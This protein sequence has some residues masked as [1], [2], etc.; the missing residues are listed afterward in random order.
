MKKP[1]IIL[2]NANI[3]GFDASDGLMLYGMLKAPAKKTKRAILHVHGL[4]GSFYGSNSVPEI[5]KAAN[6]KGIAFMSI[7]TRGSYV[8]E[9]FSYRNGDSLLAGGALEKFEDSRHDIEGAI[10]ALMAMDYSEIFLEGHSTGCQKILYYMQSEFYKRHKK[11][12][13]G[14]ALLAPV[15]DYSY[16]LKRFGNKVYTKR[17]ITA[18]AAKG[19]MLFMPMPAKPDSGDIIG[20]ERFL[21]TAIKSMPEA[22]MLYYRGNLGSI[23]GIK[24]P[25]FAAFGSHD[26]YMVDTKPLEALNAIR[27]KYKGKRLETVIVKNTG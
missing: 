26:E 18:L 15:D 7:L 9:D 25:L 5:S 6:A 12:I 10:K 14:I 20:P 23:S 3:V 11:H 24:V 1:L 19:K 2:G 17:R 16:D 27:L 22:Q 21:S 4:T 13:R 8:V